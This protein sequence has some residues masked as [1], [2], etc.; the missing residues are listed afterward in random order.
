MTDCFITQP[1]HPDGIALLECAGFDIRVASSSDMNCIVREIGAAEI[2]ITRDAGLTGAAMRAAPRL[3]MIASHGVGINR[4]DL[5]QARSQGILITNTPATNTHA[6]AEYTIGLMLALAR[7]IVDADHA[8]RAHNW[9]F[10]HS[11]GMIELRGRQ[12]GL[13]GFGTIARKVAFMA[14]AGFGMHVSVW[15]PNTPDDVVAAAGVERASSLSALLSRSDV[16]SLHRPLREDTLNM[17]NET[18]LGFVKPGALLINTGRGGLVD[19]PALHKALID[20][21]IGA[22]ALDVFTT[23]PPAADDLVR[24]LPRTIL[25]PHLGGSTQEALRETACLCARQ[26]IAM[27]RGEMPPHVVLAA[28]VDPGL[29][30]KK[31]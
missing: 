30:I 21:R 5:E 26:A 14:Q 22:A 10:R 25:T 4:I 11:A 16:I 24:Q 1:I 13:V 6:V 8:V 27:S 18:S 15:S 3:R 17:I 9:G 2:V 23:E 19:I 31:V 29:E 20:G 7:R 28:G 12:L